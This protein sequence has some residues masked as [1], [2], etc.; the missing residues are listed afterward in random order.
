MKTDTLLSQLKSPILLAPMLGVVTPEM[1]AAVSNHGALGGLPLGGQSPEKA[2]QL[3][4]KTKSLTSEIFA[5][6]LFTHSKPSL[7]Q[8]LTKVEKMK[9]YLLQK[10]K[11]KQWSEQYDFNYSFYPYQDLIDIIIAEE[12]KVVSFTFG[13]LDAESIQKLKDHSILIIGTATCLEEAMLLEKSGIDMVVA[14]GIEAGGHRGGFLEGDLPQVGLFSLLPQL[15]ENLSIPVIASGGIYDHKTMQAAFQ[16]GAQAVQI[17]SYF[18]AAT[19]S[20]ATDTYRQLLK[21]SKD[22]STML[23]KSFSGRWARGIKNEWMME[24]QDMEIPDYP[25]QN[26]LTQPLRALA[27]AHGDIEYTNYWAGQNAHHAKTVSTQEIIEELT[28]IYKTIKI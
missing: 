16:L 9:S 7:E 3:I 4:Q 22:T 17:G 6:N 28:N 21:Q 1:V 27:K 14:Q 13:R 19:E 24:T 26:L 10:V 5:V 15:V 12:I 8:N 2:L 25:L 18:I 11:D 23:T 20:L